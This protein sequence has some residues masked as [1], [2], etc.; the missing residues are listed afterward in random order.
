MW[1]N[2]TGWS[3]RDVGI[4]D[5]DVVPV[6]TSAEAKDGDIIVAHIA[7][8]GQVVK[9]LRIASDKTI[10]LESA[11]PDFASIEIDDNGS[12]KVHGVVIGRAGKV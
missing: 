5:G 8:H 3:I 4:N 6:D 11:N 1:V 2:V 7:G 9:R 12:A 10:V